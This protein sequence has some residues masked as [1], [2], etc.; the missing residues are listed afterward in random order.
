MMNHV[1]SCSGL[2]T[3]VLASLSA[4]VVR[5]EESRSVT[6]D[7]GLVVSVRQT[8]PVNINPKRDLH[9]PCVI[10]AANGELLLSHQ[11]SDKHGG[12]DGFAHQWR[13]ADNGLTWKDEG[14]VADWRNRKI[15]SLFGEYGLAVDGRLT[16]IVQRRKVLGGDPGIIGSWL[17]TS[18][19]HGKTW[20]EIG[21][22]DDSHEYAVMFG[23]NII[24][25]AGVM[26]VGV[27]SRLGNALYVSADHGLT[28]QKRSVIFP[29]EYPDFTNLKTAGPPFYPHV[30]FCPDGSLLA[31]TYHTPPKNHCYSRR[32]R[33]HGKT[34]GPIVKETGLRLWAPRMNR[35]DK[36]TLIV[37]GRD[38]GER[39]TVAWFSTNQGA[40]WGHKLLLDKPKFPGSYAYT[41][42]ISAGAGKFWVFTSSPQSPG[43][44]DIVGVLLSTTMPPA[45]GADQ[46][47]PAATSSRIEMRPYRWTK[48]PYTEHREA[49]AT[50]HDDGLCVDLRAPWFEK[51]ER[52]IL[53]TSEIV[54]FDN[55]YLYDDHFPTQEQNGRG[56]DYQHIRFHWNTQ[57]A[58]HEL[59]ASCQVPDKGRFRLRL[60]ARS[61]YVDISLTVRNDLKRAMKYV[62]WYFCPVAYE[63]PTINDPTQRRTWLFD[64]QRLR[65]LAEKSRGIPAEEMYPIGG[66][67]GAGG[68]IPPL[69]A[70][71]PRGVIEA[72]APIV[73][74][75]N[76][77]GT[78]TV[79]LAFDRAHSI[80]SSRGNG[81]FHADPYFGPDIKPREERT[82]HGRLYLAEGSPQDVLE[83]F[84]RD[85]PAA[86][87]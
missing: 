87:D 76:A 59:S 52:L 58:P 72:K 4:S 29:T 9:G 26:Y 66:A 80:F 3:L 17:Q 34:W 79:A 48:S 16:M 22:V 5:T 28:W 2:M 83:R 12:G 44:G 82:V 7:N 70:A 37:T 11:D 84:Q 74:V 20:K 77:R 25:H 68:F 19:D 40:T 53:R 33:D 69:H 1:Q 30:T 23:R 32:S 50:P 8:V 6:L 86:E 49:H 45:S 35:I 18:E 64:G 21:A 10:R 65:T 31:M 71:H 81:C 57:G 85:F 51:G 60:V 73:L 36:E 78:H 24:T 55:G 46:R 14:P 67:R 54:G 47:R 62:D 75:S 42:S 39:A 15:D 38:I 41:D 56:K 43:R 13:S 63:A 27:W 61:D